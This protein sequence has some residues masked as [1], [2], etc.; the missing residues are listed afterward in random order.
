[1]GESRTPQQ[2][3]PLGNASLVLGIL[4]I[5]MVFGISVCAFTATRQGW[6]RL[7]ATPLYVCGASSAFLGLVGIG[8]GGAG[9]FGADRS[10]ATAIAGLVLGLMGVCLFLVAVTQVGRLA[11]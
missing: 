5:A 8:L 6:I 2:P 9:L 10:R 7:G 3:N 11:G 4:S 1:M